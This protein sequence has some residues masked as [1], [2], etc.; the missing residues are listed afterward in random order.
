MSLNV[1]KWGDGRG[2]LIQDE[3]GRNVAWV[4]TWRIELV[5]TISEY[6]GKQ[7]E[8]FRRAEA[9]ARKF[10]AAEE[11]YTAAADMVELWRAWRWERSHPVADHNAR[12]SLE[13]RIEEI[14][15][16]LNAADGRVPHE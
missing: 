13:M 5:A 10:A 16:A 7:E 14:S 15:A 9:L 11:L 1:V 4:H 3:A 6:K 2:F 12:R 8:E